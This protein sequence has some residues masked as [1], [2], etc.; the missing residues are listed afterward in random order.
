MDQERLDDLEAR[1][2]ES[3]AAKPNMVRV[4]QAVYAHRRLRLEQ[5]VDVAETA[6]DCPRDWT[7]MELYALLCATLLSESS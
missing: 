6:L 2:R 3:E 1:L 7:T 5:I 4:V